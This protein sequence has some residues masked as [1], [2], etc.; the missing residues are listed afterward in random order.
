MPNTVKALGS[1]LSTKKGEKLAGWGG[2]EID[3]LGYLKWVSFRKPHHQTGLHSELSQ[4]IKNNGKHYYNVKHAYNLST[5]EG[6]AERA[7]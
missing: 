4:K 1:T 5:H 7:P 6:E 3:I 2:K